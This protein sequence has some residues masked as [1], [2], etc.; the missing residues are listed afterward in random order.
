MDPHQ[1]SHDDQVAPISHFQKVNV[2]KTQQN[3]LHVN[4]TDRFN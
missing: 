4:S 3:C 1:L 2:P